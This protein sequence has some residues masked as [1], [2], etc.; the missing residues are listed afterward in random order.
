MWTSILNILYGFIKKN[1]SLILI[2][3]LAIALFFSVRST[4]DMKEQY[5][6]ELGNV[7]ALTTE[8]ELSKTKN[9]E[10]VATIQE[11][12]YTV[13]E[14]KK[15][16]AADAKL[17]RELNIRA[18]EV[19]EVVKTVTETK[20]VY[21]DTFMMIRPDSLYNWKKDTRWWSVDQK[22]N[23]AVNPPVVEFNFE[24]R[25]S[26]TFLLYKVP[27][28]KFL[29]IHWGVKCYEIKVINHNP[30]STITYARWINISK[31]RGRRKRE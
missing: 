21:R 20:I 25:D 27:K 2:A 15:R 1:W 19:R 16:Q 18:N 24:S 26:L 4:V 14:F 23:M 30:N 3:L 28:C 13:E 12:Q 8:L 10:T 29:G 5:L 11:L 7:N 17:I 31:D 9:D 22:I 6:R